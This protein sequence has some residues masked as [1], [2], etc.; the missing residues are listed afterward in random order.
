MK[1][2]F[3]AIFC[4]DWSGRPGR[5][6][7]VYVA[8]LSSREVRRVA[9][10]EE[11]WTVATVL[12]A[13]RAE[14]SGN[15]LVGFDAPIGLPRSLARALE[16]PTD[17]SFLYW[18]DATESASPF[19]EPVAQASEWRPHRPFF[20]VPAGPGERRKF[21]TAAA[22][23]GVELFRQVDRAVGGKCPFIVS[24]IP[25]AVGLAAIDLWR[26]LIDARRTAACP[27]VWPFE[28]FESPQHRL[29]VGEVYPRL[30][31]AIAT[32]S[33]ST[34]S[35][36]DRAARVDALAALASAAW[37]RDLGVDVGDRSAAEASE[38]AL[39]ALLSAAALLRL[40]LEGR[41]LSTATDSLEGAVLLSAAGAGPRAAETTVGCADEGASMP[42]RA[43]ATTVRRATEADLWNAPE[44][45][46]KRELVDGEVVMSP[47]GA[48]HGQVC[49]RL[50]MAIGAFVRERSLGEVFDSSTGFRLPGGNVRLPD[51]AFVPAERLAGGVTDDF[52]D[53][54][55]ALA[56]EVLSPSDRPRA[57]LDKVGE[58]L[59][60][61]VTMV[62]VVD[63]SRAS[64][65]VYRS[66]G[67]VRHVGIEGRLEGDEVLPGFSVPLRAIL[68]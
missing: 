13:A 41:P 64:A 22:R 26:G 25:G 37:V 28:N 34:A 65:A 20:R 3:E 43:M 57:V 42:G 48:R 35:K 36:G 68:E 49:V 21:E 54:T 6:R 58:Y 24:G 50:V 61:G 62:W 12:A 7:E 52:S 1:L 15:V 5:G 55:P 63:P 47:A 66:A 2:T 33:A 19:F 8:R 38:D 40:V 31:R 10:P 44:D 46:Y 51:V 16:V 39:D 67:D 59:Q 60:A 11:G 17:A 29:L 9:P 18:L 56:V 27:H 4:A 53:A 30:A 45:G 32:G 23:H 14:G